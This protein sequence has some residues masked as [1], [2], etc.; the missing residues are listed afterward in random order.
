VLGA[1]V[2]YRRIDLIGPKMGKELISNGVQAIGWALLAIM[3]Y[4]WIRFEWQFGLCAII[5]LIHDC[6]GVLCFFVLFKIEF[7][8]GAIVAFLITA[9]YSINDTV[10]IFDRV[11]ENKTYK[12]K[13]SLKQIINNSISETLPRTLLTSVTTFLALLMLYIFGGNTIADFSLPIL[14]GLVIGTYS[15]IFIAV[16]LLQFFPDAVKR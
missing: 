2:I 8:E 11:R 16:T 5:A 9:S 6:I 15:S 14:V 10:V 1:D 4:I 12:K 7:N 13:L 3:G